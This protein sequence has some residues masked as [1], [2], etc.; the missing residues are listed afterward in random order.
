MIVLPDVRGL[1]PYYEELALRFAERGIDAIAIDYFG[2]TAGD[3]ARGD[4]FEYMPHVAADAPGRASPPTSRPARRPARA[5]G[6]GRPID[7]L[8]RRVLLRRPARV[9]GG[10]AG[11]DLAGRIGF[12]GWP[13]G[14]RAT[15]CRRPVDVAGRSTAVLGIFGG[16]D[17][18]SAPD[19]VDEFEAALTAAGVEHQLVTYP[20]AP[21]SFFD[22][23]AD[24]V[25]GA[26]A[27]AWGEILEFVGARTALTSAAPSA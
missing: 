8:H 20:G 17:Q 9:P 25:R 6:A 26:S 10:D 14:R 24:R 19:A 23:K 3:R 7:C 22:R 21:H 11:S 12:Y 27:A 5:T 15:T 18:G 1:H 16:A 2:R 4:D 13:S